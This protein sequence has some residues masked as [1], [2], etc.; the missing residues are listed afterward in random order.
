MTGITRLHSTETSILS[1]EPLAKVADLRV[2]VGAD[3]SGV[4]RSRFG[5]LRGVNLG[6]GGVARRRWLCL[7]PLGVSRGGLPSAVAEGLLRV[8]PRWATVAVE[9]GPLLERPALN[10]R[11]RSRCVALS[12]RSD[13]E[14]SRLLRNALRMS[15][16]LAAADASD[17]AEPDLD[18][19]R[20]PAPP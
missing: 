18:G 3:G 2:E 11:R 13:E 9:G 7:H 10:D 1:G 8:T 6:H 4:E 14:A 19:G 17:E 20:L 12:S 5:Q 16:D 15:A